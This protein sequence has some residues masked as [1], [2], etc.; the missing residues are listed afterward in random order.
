MNSLLK[1]NVDFIEGSKLF[2]EGG[3]YSSE[4]VKWY[5]NMLKEIDEQ[6]KQNQTQRQ[7]KAKDIIELMNKKKQ[8]MLDLFEKQ[9]AISIEELACRE[10]TGKKYGRPRRLF[11]ERIRAEMTKC[12]KAQEGLK[13]F[14]KV[15]KFQIGINNNIEKLRILY[16]K[17]IEIKES[18]DHSPF[19]SDPSFSLKVRQILNR[20]RTC[21]SKY[22]KHISALKPDAKAQEMPRVSYNELKFDISVDAQEAEKVI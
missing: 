5:E 20:I 11:Q 8:E 14:R 3:N 7:N 2:E 18:S 6:I 17:F 4:E 13:I 10:G 21:I 22:S 9:Y 15:I 19:Y 1:Q 12:E 16:K